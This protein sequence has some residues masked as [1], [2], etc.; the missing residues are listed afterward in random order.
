MPSAINKVGMR[1]REIMIIPLA[2]FAAG[3]QKRIASTHTYKFRLSG[4]LA[5]SCALTLKRARKNQEQ[6]WA[7]S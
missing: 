1:L 5:L 2:G 7:N 3:S 4:C 6:V